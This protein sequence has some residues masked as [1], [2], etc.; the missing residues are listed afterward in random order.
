MG[1]S[2]KPQLRLR[3]DSRVR[4]GFRGATITSDAGLLAARELDEALGLTSLSGMV[5]RESRKGR[6]VQHQLVPLLRQSVYSRLAGYEDTND[7]ERLAQDP[8][9]R[10]IA[11]WREGN[12]P[13]ASTNTVSR[14]E[15]ETLTTPENLE[16]LSKLNAAWVSRAVGRTS[17]QRAILDLDSSESEVH[18]EQEGAAYNGHFGSTCYHPLFCF[19]QFGDCEGALLRPG[20]V[21][22]AEQ[23]REVL[24]P[25]VRRHRSRGVRVLCRADAAF[26]KP[27]V[28]DF[29]EA[30][31]VG[32][33]IRLPSNEVLEEHTRH[34]FQ[35]PEGELPGQPVVRYHDFLYQAKSWDRAR[36]VVA[37]VEWHRGELLPSWGFIVTNLDYPPKGVSRFYNGRG[38]AEQWI[39]EGK[40]AL[41]WTRLSCH[42][43]V[44][45]QVRLWLFVLAYNLGNFLRRLALPKAIKNWSLRSVQVKLIKM[46]GRLV[47]HARRLVF[48]LA[49]VAVPRALFQAILDRIGQLC[50]AP[51]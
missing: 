7:A 16:G 23:W 3:F 41:N 47:R 18:G 17:H 19:N 34:L 29:L 30:E 5:L 27:E 8:A 14:F 4:L 49:E 26:A 11:G 32:Y 25:V 40:Y 20:N 33:A 42:R 50:P 15:T 38:T 24:E 28:Y 36:R 43:F 2:A 46:G 35:R 13:A 6:N 9:M 51:G 48:Q 39:K 12:R 1:E 37:K 45:N 10:V 44:A 22:S 21:H 31:C